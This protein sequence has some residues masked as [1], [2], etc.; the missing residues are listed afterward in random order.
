MSLRKVILVGSFTL[1]VL[2]A[3]SLSISKPSSGHGA[4]ETSGYQ[5]SVFPKA[6][7]HVNSGGQCVTDILYSQGVPIVVTCCSNND[8]TFYCRQGSIG[9]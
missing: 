2:A 5:L 1:A 6:D 3:S 4:S 8:G 7:A 9:S